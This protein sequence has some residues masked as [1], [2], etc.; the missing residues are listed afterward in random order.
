MQ[1]ARELIAVGASDAVVRMLVPR[2]FAEVVLRKNRADAC[3]GYVV[4]GAELWGQV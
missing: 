3:E 1:L 4:L 2:R